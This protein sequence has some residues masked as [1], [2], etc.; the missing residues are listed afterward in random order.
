M[1][2]RKNQMRPKMCP[3][4]GD[5]ALIE[6]FYDLKWGAYVEC[7]NLACGARGPYRVA[8]FR[9]EAEAMA[10]WAWARPLMNNRPE[11]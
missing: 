5:D 11:L 4:C 6:S 1:N 9:Y 10:I 3:W 7:Y 8:E 2:S